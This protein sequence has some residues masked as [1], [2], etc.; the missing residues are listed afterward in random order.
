MTLTQVILTNVASLIVCG[1]S[2]YAQHLRHKRYRAAIHALLGDEGYVPGEVQSM[3]DE[4]MR[5]YKAL[6]IDVPAPN[7]FV[8]HLM[9]QPSFRKA[10]AHEELHRIYLETH[11]R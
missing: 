4:M 5:T 2:M 9:Q 1:V 3:V 8:H 6:R 7:V 10:V 11:G